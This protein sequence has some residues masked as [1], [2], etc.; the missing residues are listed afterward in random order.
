MF[1]ITGSVTNSLE[2]AKISRLIKKKINKCEPVGEECFMFNLPD[3]GDHKHH[4]TGA[5]ISEPIDQ[6]VKEKIFSLVQSG[7]HK[8][9]VISK[10]LNVFVENELKITDRLKKGYYPDLRTI[11][12]FIYKAKASPDSIKIDKRSTNVTDQTL[13]FPKT[14]SYSSLNTSENNDSISEIFEDDSNDSIT[15]NFKEF[16]PNEILS[17]NVEELN[18][19]LPENS[20]GDESNESSNIR[21]INKKNLISSCDS[22]IQLI[23]SIMKYI[24]EKKLE[25]L[26]KKLDELIYMFAN[27]VTTQKSTRC[28][29]KSYLPVERKHNDKLLPHDEQSSKL[30]GRPAKATKGS[31]VK[32]SHNFKFPIGTKTCAT[33]HINST[34]PAKKINPERI[35]LPPKEKPSDISIALVASKIVSDSQASEVNDRPTYNNFKCPNKMRSSVIVSVKSVLSAERLSLENR[36]LQCEEEPKETIGAAANRLTASNDITVSQ[37]NKIVGSDSLKRQQESKMIVTK[38]KKDNPQPPSNLQGCQSDHR[39]RT[40]IS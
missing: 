4:S 2:R 25:Q 22:S 24:N 11:R 5:Y 17:E 13:Q 8:A 34:L 29:V 35:L 23:Q 21:E 14:D 10:L 6:R 30:G 31:I 16:V 36:L 26:S 18:E 1:Q 19:T 32:N 40:K 20:E 39:Y 28:P 27:K 9:V 7:E 37:I 38:R 15:K 12:K 3:V 33:L